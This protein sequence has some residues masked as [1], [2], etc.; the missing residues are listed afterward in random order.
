MSDKPKEQMFP[1][2][3]PRL[4]SRQPHIPPPSKPR[5]VRKPKR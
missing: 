4:G 1:P 3:N 2:A 5:P